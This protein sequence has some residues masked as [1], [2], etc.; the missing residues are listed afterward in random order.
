MPYKPLK[1]CKYPGC[2]KLTNGSYC[3][4]HSKLMYKRYNNTQRDKAINE[5]Y[6]EEWKE[7]RQQYIVYKPYCEIC[8]KYGKL[9]KADEV[10]HIKPLAEGGT[11]DFTNL[12]SL[13]HR[14]HAK[15]HA[16]RGDYLGNKKKAY[17]Y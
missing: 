8:R 12:I 10:H 13:C 4:D 16:E 3:I 6:D 7:V 5:R 11:H 9:I 1:P 15:I 14:C 2:N 17:T